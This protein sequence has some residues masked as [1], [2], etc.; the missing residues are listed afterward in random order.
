MYAVQWMR[1]RRETSAFFFHPDGPC[2]A[3]GANSVRE[4]IWPRRLPKSIVTVLRG[5]YVISPAL[6]DLF[7]A[8]LHPLLEAPCALGG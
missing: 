8:D 1:N 6:A 2:V 3:L 5:M 4:N 7:W